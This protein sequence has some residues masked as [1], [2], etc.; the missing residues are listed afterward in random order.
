MTREGS[1]VAGQTN[2][3]GEQ[4]VEGFEPHMLMA[5]SQN[6]LIILEREGQDFSHNKPGNA[7]FH[8]ALRTYFC[9]N[10]SIVNDQ[11]QYESMVMTAEKSAFMT[12]IIFL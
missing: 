3:G 2:Y 4:E 11:I 1:V 5:S 12:V 7:L 9:W 10:A 8:D 6:K